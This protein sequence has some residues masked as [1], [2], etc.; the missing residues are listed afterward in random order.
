MSV[1]V[2][3]FYK[4]VTI[5]D[6]EDLRQK[7][8]ALG[9]EHGIMGTILIATEGINST[10]AGSDVGIRALLSWLRA[11]PRFSDLGSKES[12]ADEMPFR[13]FKVRIRPEIVTLRR[14]EANPAERVGRYVKPEQWNELISDPDV[15]VIDTRNSYEVG[16]GT[17]KGAVDPV[18]SAFNEFPDFVAANLSPEKHKR[19]AMF[20]TGGIRC[21]KAS[22]YMLSQ[23]FPE[24]YHLEGGI[25]KYLETVPPEQSL[26]EGECFVFDR[27]VAVEHGVKQGSY[28]MCFDCGSPIAENAPQCPNC[29]VADEL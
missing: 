14:P 7:L 17:F 2:T 6:L 10:V 4:F 28:I 24:V 19:V 29:S 22:A 15:V 5:A 1:T 3:A 23:G 18:T 13:R 26:W 27:R 8:L 25:L 16:I 21:E 11:D 20:C 9:A 12:Y